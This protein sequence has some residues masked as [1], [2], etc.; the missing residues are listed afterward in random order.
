MT[1][2]PKI[3]I[4]TPSF[5]QGAFIEETIQ[6]VLSQDYPN[7]EYMIIDG[8]STDDTLD[9]LYRYQDQLTWISEADRGQVDAINKG[10]KLA[11]G[12]V[13]AYLNSDDL[14]LPGA[15]RRVGTYFAEHPQ[16]DWLTGYCQ[17]VDGDGRP[18]RGL[19]RAY[20]IFWLRW[21][22]YRVLL[23]LNYIAQPA[24]FWRRRVTEAIGPLDESLNYTME[25]QYWLRIGAEHRLH[26]LKEDLAVFRLHNQSK[27]GN[28]AHKQFEEELGVARGFAGPVL[29][30]LHKAHNAVVIGIYKHILG[31]GREE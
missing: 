8:G 3:S 18:I 2:W 1:E 6:S 25:Y 12:E 29:L 22:S 7:L 5:N 24:T 20:K 15:L 13:L 26:V 30:G 10:L 16:A 21:P 4:I 17:N 23:V 19:I 31:L 14:Y 9:I 11:S 27:S 28:T